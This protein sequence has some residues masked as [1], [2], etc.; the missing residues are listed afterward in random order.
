MRLKRYILSPVDQECIASGTMDEELK[1]ALH[2]ETYTMDDDRFGKEKTLIIFA[3]F[4]DG[5]GE[6]FEDKVVRIVEDD[7]KNGGKIIT[8]LRNYL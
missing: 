6:S 1:D 4:P 2:V 7:I 5:T 3:F 8:K